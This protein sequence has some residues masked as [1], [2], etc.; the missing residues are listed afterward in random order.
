V[1]GGQA[2]ASWG[3]VEDPCE[4]GSF[5]SEW[6]DGWTAKEVRRP[7]ILLEVTASAHFQPR[8]WPGPE[9]T[10]YDKQHAGQGSYGV[11]KNEPP[12][13]IVEVDVEKITLTAKE[14]Y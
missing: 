13:P 7:L 12:I 2:W 10:N 6:K 11:E 14:N 3:K 4:A 5:Q 1:D 9:C 8:L